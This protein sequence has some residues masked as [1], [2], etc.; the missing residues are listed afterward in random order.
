MEAEAARIEAQ[1]AAA[2]SAPALEK[3]DESENG[4]IKKTRDKTKDGYIL[5]NGFFYKIGYTILD[6]GV[7][8]APED[9]GKWKKV[10]DYYFKNF[11]YEKG[12]NPPPGW[13]L[14]RGTKIYE[15]T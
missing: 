1:E 11:A 12:D 9:I 3:Y 5:V 14:K 8:P 13:K 15:K 10:G 7:D 2:A 4:I 6:K